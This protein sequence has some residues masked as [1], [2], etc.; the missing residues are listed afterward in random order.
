LI[1]EE[2]FEVEDKALDSEEK[3]EAEEKE[4]KEDKD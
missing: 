1:N 3:E 4:V 2:F